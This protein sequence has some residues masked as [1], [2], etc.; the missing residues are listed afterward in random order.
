MC[1][2]VARRGVF[3]RWLVCSA[4]RSRAEGLRPTPWTPAHLVPAPG[5]HKALKVLQHAPCPHTRRRQVRAPGHLR[6]E[7]VY[8]LLPRLRAGRRCLLCPITRVMLLLLLWLQLGRSGCSCGR[9][10]CC[11]WGFAAGVEC[12]LGCVARGGAC[13]MQAGRQGVLQAGVRALRA[14]APRHAG[15]HALRPSPAA[16]TPC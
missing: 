7:E 4:G 13:R 15:M 3:L 9:G 11:A 6:D 12:G 2:C 8:P 14:N 10:G 1:V 5:L 16:P